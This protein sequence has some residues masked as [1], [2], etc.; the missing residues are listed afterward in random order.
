[1]HTCWSERLHAGIIIFSKKIMLR[2]LRLVILLLAVGHYAAGNDDLRCQEISDVFVGGFSGSGGNGDPSIGVVY[3]SFHINS[4][5]VARYAVTTITSVVVNNDTLSRELAF[6]VQIP[7][8]A[9]IS[10]FTM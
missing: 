5:V 6:L 1:M 8:T 2:E 4:E 7:D 3:R 9:F 10:N